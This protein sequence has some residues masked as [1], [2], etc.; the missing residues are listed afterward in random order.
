VAIGAFEL[1]VLSD[2]WEKGVQRARASGR[3]YY[4]SRIDPR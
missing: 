4:V 1:G 2:Q 3:E